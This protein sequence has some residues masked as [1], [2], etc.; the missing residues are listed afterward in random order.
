MQIIIKQ[1]KPCDLQEQPFSL[2]H[3]DTYLATCCGHQCIQSWTCADHTCRTLERLAVHAAWWKFKMEWG[4][5]VLQRVNNQCKNCEK[6]FNWLR[7]NLLDLKMQLVF[8]VHAEKTILKDG[9]SRM[10]SN[11]WNA[12]CSYCCFPS[13]P[14][15]LTDKWSNRFRSHIETHGNAYLTLQVQSTSQ[16]LS[17]E[18]STKSLRPLLSWLV[19]SWCGPRNTC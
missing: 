10:A 7:D 6:Q 17:F 18:L 13:M 4:S 8:S 3:I 19:F 9:A 11:H 14:G 12:R 2:T 1:R 16:Y 15:N 5:K